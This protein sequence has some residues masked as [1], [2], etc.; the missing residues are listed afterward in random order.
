M[1]WKENLGNGKSF[2]A[3]SFLILLIHHQM[4]YV[5]MKAW[6]FGNRLPVAGIDLGRCNSPNADQKV[7]TDDGVV[8]VGG[9]W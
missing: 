3:L 4:N 1:A 6:L 9:A 2:E 5:V 7:W 8:V